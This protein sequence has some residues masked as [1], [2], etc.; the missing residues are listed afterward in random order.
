MA[1]H[2]HPDAALADE[3][4]ERW[5]ELL[6]RF[7]PPGAEPDAAAYGEQLVRR[8]GEPQR[9]YHTLRHL[10]AVL[11]AVDALAGP[12]AR[13]ADVV[14]LAAWFH[15]AVYAPDRSENEERSARLAERVLAELGL[16]PGVVAE[17]ARLV[18]LTVD[19]DPAPGDTAGELLCDAD[20]AV[21]GGPPGAYA[22]Y[23]AAVR[24]EYAFVP[25]PDFRRGRAAVLRQLLALP[26]LFRTPGGVAAYQQRARANL[27]GELR[28]LAG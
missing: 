14:R 16:A 9:R 12:Q 4:V 21:L 23:A 6:G 7:R 28:Q 15:D 26:R 25:E 20:L 10:D 19:H 3:L 13:D 2:P 11:R 22:A 8:W 5:G 18:R 24:E 1:P 27:A 17:T